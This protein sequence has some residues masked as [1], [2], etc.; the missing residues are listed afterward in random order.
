MQVQENQA[1]ISLLNTRKTYATQVATKSEQKS[2]TEITPSSTAAAGIT[3]QSA[4]NAVTGTTGSHLSA[5]TTAELIKATQQAEG[6]SERD[7]SL[8]RE[9]ANNPALAS[10][11]ARTANGPDPIKGINLSSN[12]LTAADKAGLIPLGDTTHPTAIML[13]QRGT[14]AESELKQ[15]TPPAEVYMHILEFN[16]NL[17][18]SYGDSLDQ[19]GQTPPGAWNKHQQAMA[20]YLKQAIAQANSSETTGDLS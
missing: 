5:G 12:I 8:M 16:A 15:G 10:Q 13:N 14:M 4:D 6:L 18:Q 2:T 20:D 11:M 17:P 19:T 7:K 1:Y 3:S 9:I